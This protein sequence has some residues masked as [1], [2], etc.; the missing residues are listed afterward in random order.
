MNEWILTK[1][2]HHFVEFSSL[3]SFGFD[4]ELRLILFD[5]IDVVCALCACVCVCVWSL[6]EIDTELMA[7]LVSTYT[8][9]NQ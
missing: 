3:N 7:M 8:N 6:N 9:F 2:Q 5:V 1:A 4:G